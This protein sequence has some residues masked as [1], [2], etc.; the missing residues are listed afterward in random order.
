MFIENVT[1]GWI[2]ELV[3]EHKPGWSLTQ[4][5]Y[6][7]EK[8]YGLD[9]EKIYLNYWLY[10]GHKSQI[11]KPGSYF[12]VQLGSEPVLIVRGEDDQV[13]ALINVCRHRGSMLCTDAA[14]QLKKLVCPYHQWVYDLDGTLRAAKLMPEEFDKTSFHLHQIHCRELE[15]FLF[16]SFAQDPP[17]FD[18]LVSIY[19]PHMKMYDME[20]TKVA[21][22]GRYL[23]NSNW[24]LIAENFR[25][26]YHCGVGHPEYCSVII[27][28]NLDQ[29]RERAQGV[30]LEKNRTWESKGIPI[31]KSLFEN[32]DIWYYCERYPYQPGFTTMSAD[33]RPVSV[34]L[35]NLPDIDVG[36]WSIVQYPNFWL[37]INHDYAWAMHL[38]P[39][40]AT[41]TEVRAQ[42]LVRADAVE[43]RDYEIDKLIWFWKTTAEQDW[44]LCEDNQAGV[45]SRYY[46]PGPYSDYAEGG[47]GQFV[48]WYL[49]AI[50]K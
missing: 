12:T 10:V 2:D 25:E 30:R 21:Y 20:K 5:F 4:P 11:P 45:N 15:G 48:D 37:D 27:G 28:A 6:T 17:D 8:I 32:Q 44:K 43:G 35:G 39:V 36:V 29:G 34:P 41:K 7:D 38:L 1:T 40:S 33:G 19:K 49:S 42:W 9:L 16:I 23:V 18:H 3:E 24:K 22:T 26:C 50:R 14:G 47:P 46:R 13:R 31:Y